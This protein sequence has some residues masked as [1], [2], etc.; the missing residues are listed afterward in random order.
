MLVGIIR[1]YF[2]KLPNFI[3]KRGVKTHFMVKSDILSLSGYQIK[4]NLLIV[5]KEVDKTVPQI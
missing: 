5:D 2:A 3:Q 4:I 1:I